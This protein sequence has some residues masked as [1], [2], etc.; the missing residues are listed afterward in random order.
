MSDCSPPI[1]EELTLLATVIGMYLARMFDRRTATIIAQF[2]NNIADAMLTILVQDAILF[3]QT[4]ALNTN[5]NTQTSAVSEE[6]AANLS[7]G[8]L[9]SPPAAK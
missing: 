2:I 4:T 5:N 3:P 7:S 9:E 6:T 8:L 1:P